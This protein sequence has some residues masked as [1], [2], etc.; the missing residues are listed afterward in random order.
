MERSA[1]ATRVVT[2]DLSVQT[3]SHATPRHAVYAIQSECLMRHIARDK[4]QQAIPFGKCSIP[5]PG[6]LFQD[7]TIL[8]GC[9]NYVHVI[10]IPD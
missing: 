6:L 9:Q 3:M 1:E 8:Y 7:N 10:M 2:C 5:Y 4:S